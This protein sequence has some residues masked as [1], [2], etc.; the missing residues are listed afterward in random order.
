MHWVILYG[1]RWG[2]WAWK[3]DGY[4]AAI[5]KLHS[6]GW[7][8]SAWISWYDTGAKREGETKKQR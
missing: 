3:S 7:S 1:V 5:G 6:V 2:E 8:A 4:G